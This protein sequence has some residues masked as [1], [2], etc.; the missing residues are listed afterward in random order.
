MQSKP[1][2]APEPVLSPQRDREELPPMINDTLIDGDDSSDDDISG[3][4]GE[5]P[6]NEQ[7]PLVTDTSAKRPRPG[8]ISLS[9]SAINS[10]MRRVFTPTLKGHLKVSKE[11]MD[12]W[13]A[14]PT[15]TKRKQLEQI[16]QM[17]GY[18]SDL[19]LLLCL[20]SLK[21]PLVAATVTVSLFGVIVVKETFLG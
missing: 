14:G 6:L 18:D 11:I 10:R 3:D 7:I 12:D 9:R 4:E 8:E 17:C 19:W 2:V 16:F 13:H 5:M 21:Y 15:S 20:F 1:A